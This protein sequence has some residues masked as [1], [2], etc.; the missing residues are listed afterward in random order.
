MSFTFFAYRN[1]YQRS[2]NVEF[3]NDQM[4]QNP[5]CHQRLPG[6]HVAPAEFIVCKKTVI[7]FGVASFSAA[8]IPSY[9][10]KQTCIVEADV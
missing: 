4:E 6:L 9:R 8:G 2:L 1:F 3:S 5:I 10:N 7:R